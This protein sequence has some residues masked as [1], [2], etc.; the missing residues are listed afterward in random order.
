LE[1]IWGSDSHPKTAPIREA[2]KKREKR[3]EE[4]ERDLQ[5]LRSL[6]ETT[7]RQPSS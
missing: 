2:I 5:T 7:T 6:L 4:L 1:V 3:K